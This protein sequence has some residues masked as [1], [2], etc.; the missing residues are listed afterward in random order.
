MNLHLGFLSLGV[1][2]ILPLAILF[3]LLFSFVPA[4]AFAQV[5]TIDSITGVDPTAAGFCAAAVDGAPCRTNAFFGFYEVWGQCRARTCVALALTPLETVAIGIGANLITGVISA[6]LR[7]NTAPSIGPSFNIGGQTSCPSGRYPTSDPYNRDPCAQYVVPATPPPSN[8]DLVGQLLGRCNV[9]TTTPSTD[10][11]NAS[12]TVVPSAGAAPLPVTF[13]VTD[14]STG[15]PRAGIILSSGDSTAPI[16]AFP[17]ISACA[18]ARAPAVFTYTYPTAGTFQATLKNQTTQATLQSVTVSVTGAATSTATAS[19]LASPS[20]GPA[21][22]S[23]TFTITDTS[24]AGTPPCSRSAF[25]FF[26]GDGTAAVTALPATNTCVVRSPVA[27]THTYGTAGTFQASLMNQ[28]ANITIQTATIVV[29]SG[30]A[31]SGTPVNVSSSLLNMVSN[32]NVPNS[33]VARPANAAPPPTVYTQSSNTSDVQLT[34]NGIT[35]ISGGVRD[36]SRNT[37]ISAFFGADTQAGVTAQNLTERMCLVR[38]WQNPLTA[39]RIQPSI[40]DGLCSGKGFRTGVV[41]DV[42]SAPVAPVTEPAANQL[43]ATPFPPDVQPA[44][45]I[46]A[47]PASVS[48]GS[49]TSIFWNSRGVAS[50]I[51]TSPDGSFNDNRLS[52]SASTVPLTGA[53]VFSISCLTQSGSPVTNFVRVNIG[54]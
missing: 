31:Q 7:P 13:T 22:L 15:C 49:R 30:S 45:A 14:T 34:P 10:T 21:P 37:G 2:K 33:A 46:W 16:V 51:V 17:A 29:T 40:F 9:A 24:P 43:Q 48:L 1:R 53:T 41:A 19:L 32:L 44:V 20:S 28:A 3:P 27:L 25:V 12:L 6:A 18:T 4:I 47:T 39:S 54:P 11:T 26:P 38:P 8:C 36:T 35:F 5:P 52:G 42:S 23:V 50:C